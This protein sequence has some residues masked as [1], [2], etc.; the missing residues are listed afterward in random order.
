MLKIENLTKIFNKE[1]GIENQKIALNNVSI[2][3]N[4]GDFVTIIGGNGSGK[5]TLMNMISGVF[6]ADEGQIFIDDIN[7]THMPEHKRAKYLG[8]VFQ[9]PLMGTAPNM[10]ILENLEIASRRCKRS[11]F[12]WGFSK[13]N[14]EEFLKLISSLN[15]GLET[16]LNQKVGLLSGGQRQ[17]LTLLMATYV[18]PKVLLLDE[19][20]AALDP[21]TASKVLDLTEKVVRENELTTL[22]IT[23]NMKD[24]IKYG[25]RLIMLSEGKLILDISGEEKANLTIEDLLQKFENTGSTVSDKL[26]F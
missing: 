6:E 21:K 3:I 8:R 19:H 16:R 9:D 14:E 4:K 26:L 2:H 20:T 25:N 11:T 7:V 10:S 13:E 17:A 1:E 12:R 24:A 22:M 5:S 23:H 15:L 18:K